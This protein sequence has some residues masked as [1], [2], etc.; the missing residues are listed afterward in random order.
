MQNPS[1]S[2]L[3]GTRVW[4]HVGGMQIKEREGGGRGR[5][6]W[7]R[8]RLVEVGGRGGADEV[9]HARRGYALLRSLLIVKLQK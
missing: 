6:K 5:E 9:R 3:F 4:R 8:F 2:P 7:H 1:S